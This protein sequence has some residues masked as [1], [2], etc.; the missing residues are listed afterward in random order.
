M[1]LFVLFF[2]LGVSFGMLAVLGIVKV[3][4]KSFSKGDTLE[5][6]LKEVEVSFKQLDQKYIDLY[7]EVDQM[8]NIL[9][10]N[11]FEKD[12]DIPSTLRTLNEKIET[13]RLNYEFD[14]KYSTEAIE[15]LS[16]DMLMVRKFVTRV[17]SGKDY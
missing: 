7:M 9:K 13:V 4:K 3:A 8:R 17:V 15:T 6:S 5:R 10:I 12:V 14:K 16:Q 1:E 11:G 2:M